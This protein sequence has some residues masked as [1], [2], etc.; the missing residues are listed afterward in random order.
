L[1]HFGHGIGFSQI[2]WEVFSFAK[3]DPDPEF[4]AILKEKL[5]SRGLKLEDTG[6][7]KD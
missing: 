1:I 5:A 6:N 7:S 3:A 2:G 4:V